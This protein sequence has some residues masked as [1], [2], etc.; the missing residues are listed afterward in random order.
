[1]GQGT[2]RFHTAPFPLMRRIVVDFG[3]HWRKTSIVYGL[4][5][6]DITGPREF[7]RRHKQLTG[8]TLSLTA[9]V[10]TALSRAVADNPAVHAYL[11]WRNRLVVFEDVDVSVMVEAKTATGTFPVLHVIRAADRK[12]FRQIHDEIRSVQFGCGPAQPRGQ[13][14]FLN[15][16]LRLPQ[17]LRDVAYWFMRRRPLIWKRHGGTVG[18]TSVGMFGTGGGWGIPITN[19]NLTVCV[20][21]IAEKPAYV[22]DILMKREFLD[23]T[24][25]FNHD[26]VDGGP[27]ARFVTRFKRLVESAALLVPEPTAAPAAERL[28][29]AVVKVG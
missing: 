3:R 5:E 26:I 19:Y 11:D 21:G 27:A 2:D 6:L 15:W 29:N 12:T 9:Y 18:V 16:F 20:G 28:G 24:V 4:V 7:F 22:G 25:A 1:M 10:V 23:V 13:Q 14:N 8:E 17:A